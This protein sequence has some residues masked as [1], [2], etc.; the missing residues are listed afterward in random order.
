MR[1]QRGG[2]E[3]NV[4]TLEFE[5]YTRLKHAKV[6]TGRGIEVTKCNDCANAPNGVMGVLVPPSDGL[7]AKVIGGAAKRVAVERWWD[8]DMVSACEIVLELLE[9]GYEAGKPKI[10][11]SLRE[12]SRAWA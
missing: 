7:V 11:A 8:V 9:P 12:M 10:R 2:H 6:A 4:T 3:E 5:H 1:Y